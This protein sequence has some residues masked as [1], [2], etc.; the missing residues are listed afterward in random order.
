MNSLLYQSGFQIQLDLGKLELYFP[1]SVSCLSGLKK[2]VWQ[3]GLVSELKRF[4]ISSIWLIPEK[5][6]FR[7]ASRYLLILLLPLLSNLCF[8]WYVKNDES[9]NPGFVKLSFPPE[10]QPKYN[11]ITLYVNPVDLHLF[12]YTHIKQGLLYI[13]RRVVTRP[14]LQAWLREGFSPGEGVVIAPIFPAETPPLPGAPSTFP[15]APVVFP[16]LPPGARMTYPPATHLGPVAAA[17]PPQGNDDAIIVI[18][19]NLYQQQIDTGVQSQMALTH[20]VNALSDQLD[21]QIKQSMQMI[22]QVQHESSLKKNIDAFHRQLEEKDEKITELNRKIHSM[23]QSLQGAVAPDV[24][25]PPAEVAD[26][27]D[28]EAL[29]AEKDKTIEDKKQELERLQQA[30]NDKEALSE[31]QSQELSKH[32]ERIKCLECERDT[33]RKTVKNESLQLK[34]SDKRVNELETERKRLNSELQEKVSE[35]LKEKKKLE[36]QKKQFDDTV[37]ELTETQQ[38]NDLQREAVQRLIKEKSELQ[39]DRG[40]KLTEQKEK[41]Q[42]ELKEKEKLIQQQRKE[43][44]GQLDK[45]RREHQEEK[46]RLKKN[47]T[48]KQKIENKPT[49][50]GLQSPMSSGRSDK[51]ILSTVEHVD[52]ST[53]H[54][55]EGCLRMIE[56]SRSQI[57]D[58]ITADLPVRAIGVQS[59]IGGPDMAGE[60]NNNMRSFNPLSD[61]PPSGKNNKGSRKPPSKQKDGEQDQ[62]P[63]GDEAHPEDI[64]PSTLTDVAAQTVKSLFNMALPHLL[65]VVVASILSSIITYRWGQ[66]DS[67]TNGEESQTNQDSQS[68]DVDETFMQVKPIPADIG[69]DWLE[70]ENKL[71]PLCLYLL[72]ESA[73]DTIMLLVLLHSINIRFPD[74]LMYPVFF[75]GYWTESGFSS[76]TFKELLQKVQ[77]ASQEQPFS[78]DNLYLHTMKLQDFFLEPVAR[79][80][81][82][83]R[84]LVSQWQAKSHNIWNQV[85]IVNSPQQ[86]EIFPMLLGIAKLGRALDGK[87]GILREQLEKHQIKNLVSKLLTLVLKPDEQM[88]G[89]AKELTLVMFDLPESKP[90]VFWGQTLDRNIGAGKESWLLPGCSQM[91][92]AEL[93]RD[94]FS[95]LISGVVW[96][97]RIISELEKYLTGFLPVLDFSNSVDIV[98]EYPQISEQQRI[99]TI[100]YQLDWVN[101]FHTNASPQEKLR[102]IRAALVLVGVYND[103]FQIDYDRLLHI[104]WLMQQEKFDWTGKVWAEHLQAMKRTL[105]NSEPELTLKPV[106]IRYHLKL[107]LVMIPEVR[108]EELP[109]LLEG[110]IKFVTLPHTSKGKSYLYLWS[111]HRQQWVSL[112][113][114]KQGRKISQGR[115]L[116]IYCG[117]I[118]GIGPSETELEIFFAYNQ[119]CKLRR[120]R[121]NSHLRLPE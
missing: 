102:F 92:I 96:K 39:T 55:I 58:L 15:L 59:H 49:N 85:S 48:V 30:L 79:Q 94:C 98:T 71:R 52:T 103:E 82:T 108:G 7:Y 91:P 89:R 109:G 22:T 73:S 50:T 1:V 117:A 35:L 11:N 38:E 25:E 80:A 2:M 107:T 4:S 110:P 104:T 63:P 70:T 17:T 87:H 93:K 81:E 44:E 100:N 20:Q 64:A 113:D 74:T 95:Y 120:T 47:A 21:M 90:L 51:T 69:C 105:D 66:S 24:S 8:G 31:Q 34:K 29:L 111:R 86:V 76:L 56:N 57:P 43:Y 36:N 75:W 32:K 99:D 106:W 16:P 40:K 84:W 116:N 3:N 53:G 28:H 18:P 41:H 42:K 97:A 88:G 112:V 14:W 37:K 26:D 23:Q 121:L 101:N 19:F 72:D 67:Q 61:P 68:N 54:V 114:G 60:I 65:P 115:S 10:E 13:N 6:Y 118:Y 119:E 33:A 27:T 83:L 9:I 62:P 5:N 78:V 77:S 12:D 46:K 45:L